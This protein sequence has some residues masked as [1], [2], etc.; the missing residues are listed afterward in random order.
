MS[1]TFLVTGASKGI[2][3]ALSHRLVREGHRVVGIARQP[4]GDF[5]GELVAVDLADGGATDDA[6]RDLTY[7]FAFDGAVN[8]VGFVRS[9]L[10]ARE[11]RE[12]GNAEY[13]H[14]GDDWQRLLSA[15][16]GLDAIDDRDHAGDAV[17]DRPIFQWPA[18]GDDA[19]LRH[20]CENRYG[21]PFRHK[22]VNP[23]WFIPARPFSRGI[24]A[25]F[26]GVLGIADLDRAD[27]RLQ[28]SL[29]ERN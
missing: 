5:P 14:E 10:V 15:E 22:T 11:Q 24:V 18:V 16:P 1:H 19:G 17:R 12:S 3:L 6:L 4:T 13:N 27:Q 25:A 26:D 28:M 29:T 2:G 21:A 23:K 8:N 20:E 7:R 9:Q